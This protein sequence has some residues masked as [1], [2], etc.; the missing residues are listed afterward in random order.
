[1]SSVPKPLG[2]PWAVTS[3]LNKNCRSIAIITYVKSQ[4]EPIGFW[5]A[6]NEFEG[7]L[8]ALHRAAAWNQFRTGGDDI[9]VASRV[10]VVAVAFVL[11]DFH[12]IEH[13]P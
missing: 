9:A 4:P 5:L 3:H 12:A 10:V 1:M 13:H 7:I 11:I 2:Q 8:L 6:G